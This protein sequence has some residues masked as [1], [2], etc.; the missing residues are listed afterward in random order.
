MRVAAAPTT[1]DAAANPLPS[2]TVTKN[3]NL[4]LRVS[5]RKV[6]LLGI[7]ILLVNLALIVAAALRSRVRV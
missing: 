4:R 6:V 7:D 2:L 1:E 5:E 3:T